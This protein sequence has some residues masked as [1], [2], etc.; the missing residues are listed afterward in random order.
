ML[1][2]IS[3]C[4][5][6]WIGEDAANPKKIFALDTSDGTQCYCDWENAFAFT[7]E[8][9]NSAESAQGSLPGCARTSNACSQMVQGK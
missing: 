3:T 6:G 9:K 2:L 4:E 1:R 5:N 8:M 7:G